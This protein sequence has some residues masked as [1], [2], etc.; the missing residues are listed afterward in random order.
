MKTVVWIGTILMLSVGGGWVGVIAQPTKPAAQPTEPAAQSTSAP[1]AA[2]TPPAATVRPVLE[3]ITPGTE[4]RQILRLKP[5]VNVKQTAT[6]TMGMDIGLSV[7]GKSIPVEK[8]P[9]TKV[10]FEL[11][12]DRIAANGNIDY[13]FQ[14]T[15]VDWVG[16]SPLPTELLSKLRA[17]TEALKGIVGKV[18]VDN[19]GQIKAGRFEVP[20]TISSSAR[21]MLKQIS[22]SA[23]QLSAPLPEPAVGLGAKWRIT[24]Q[25]KFNGISLKQ[26]ATYELVKLQPDQATLRIGIEQ[27]APPQTIQIPAEGTDSPANDTLALK[28]FTGQGQGTITFRFDR[29][30]P[31]A[32][33][34]QIRS[35]ATM[36]SPNPPKAPIDLDTTNQMTMTLQ[37]P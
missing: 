11:S 23:D 20:P 4:P 8:L 26:V 36:Q 17:Q 28:S 6:L 12:P 14:Y 37:S 34:L 33:T 22:H 1:T 3:L 35:N 10:A 31:T 29:L 19:R 21:Q 27:Q 30:L 2:K 5:T 13:H 18:T 15:S 16:T 9:A 7:A 32:S 25:P 24:S